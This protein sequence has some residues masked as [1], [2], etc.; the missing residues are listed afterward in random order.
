MRG[1]GVSPSGSRCASHSEFIVD[2]GGLEHFTRSREGAHT[3]WLLIAWVAHF[4]AHFRA[5]PA[6]IAPFDPI[7]AGISE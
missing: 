5:D 1:S 7:Y 2:K 4:V 3:G 6:R